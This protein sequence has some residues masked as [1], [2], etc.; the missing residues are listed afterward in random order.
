MFLPF[1]EDDDPGRP[2]LTAY[3]RI[4][5]EDG[6]HSWAAGLLIANRIGEPVELIH[7]RL[8][9][10][11]SSLCQGRLNDHAAALLLRG[12]LERCRSI[13]DRV[14]Y[15]GD[16][17]DEAVLRE[18]LGF[19]VPVIPLA[20]GDDADADALLRLGAAMAAILAEAASS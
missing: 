19:D 14:C 3:L 10:P 4:L 11:P 7:L 8:T 6:G 13:P 1:R 20:S 5:P 17:I 2:G 12:L 15:P 18:R 16:D 9:V